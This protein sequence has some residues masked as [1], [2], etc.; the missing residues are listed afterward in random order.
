MSS[1]ASV[2]GLAT[3]L[4]RHLKK[5]IGGPALV[6]AVVGFGLWRLVDLSA[7][8]AVIIPPPS[9]DEPLGA[10]SETVVLAGGC[11]WGVQGVFQHVKGVT[12]AV[13]GYSGGTADTAQYET[14]SAG[15][16]GHAE[17]V[18]VTF[19]PHQVSLG[20]ILQIYF[21]VVHDPTE[22][23]RQGPDVGSQY[24]SAIFAANDAQFEVARAYIDQLNRAR[25]FPKPVV[26]TAD[27]LT[28]F[29]PAED[30]HQDFLTLHPY[31]PYIVIN[32]LPKVADLKQLFPEIYRDTPVLVTKSGT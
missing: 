16:T 21:S 9:I 20:R 32:D 27:R 28:G 7:N 15:R 12:S 2:N 23:D 10:A 30:Y 17:S 22:L 8:A 3:A 19:D 1:N 24:R 29:Y 25:V 26:T 14:V 11:F 18:K 4:H 31:Y 13:S 5:T 6:A